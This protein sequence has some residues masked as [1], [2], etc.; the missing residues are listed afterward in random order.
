MTDVLD[1][2]SGFGVE[3]LVTRLH[4]GQLHTQ[5]IGHVMLLVGL[6][7]VVLEVRQKFPH[8]WV[9][10]L[11][12]DVGVHGQQ[13]DDLVDQSAFGLL[14]IVAGAF[15]LGEELLDLLVVLLEQHDGIGRHGL[16]LT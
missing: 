2:D 6:K 8:A 3:P 15:E 7:N 12:L 11:V 4:R 1:E 16:S 10:H 13:F 5:H 9:H 14:R